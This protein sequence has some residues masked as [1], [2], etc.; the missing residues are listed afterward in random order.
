MTHLVQVDVIYALRK[1]SLHSV[2][3]VLKEQSLTF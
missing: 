2:K 3:E 1:I